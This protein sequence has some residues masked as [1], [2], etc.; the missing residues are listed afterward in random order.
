METISAKNFRAK[1]NASA[2]LALAA[3]LTFSLAA[4]AAAGTFKRI[5]INVKGS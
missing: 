1:S 3:L 5:T 2:K 4:S